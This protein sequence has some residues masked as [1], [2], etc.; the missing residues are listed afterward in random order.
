MK[1]ALIALAICAVAAILEGA[2]AGPDV[3]KR[4]ASLRVPRWALPFRAWIVVG[5]IYY[6]LCFVVLFRLLTVQPSNLRTLALAATVM[7]MAANAAFN[8]VF[9]RWGDLRAS[10][11]FFFPYSGLALGLFVLL[12]LVDPLASAV[13]GPYL[14]YFVYATAWGYQVWCLNPRTG[15]VPQVRKQIVEADSGCAGAS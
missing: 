6:V 14:V 4:L 7:L 2:A 5:A 10:F 12:V 9:F 11:L 15:T 3:K 1:P 8:L 13:F